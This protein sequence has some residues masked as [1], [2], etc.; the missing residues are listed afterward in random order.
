MQAPQQL[1]PG[2]LGPDLAQT[3]SRLFPDTAERVFAQ[4]GPYGQCH[5]FPVVLAEPLRGPAPFH[6][7]PIGQLIEQ[8]LFALVEGQLLQDPIV[9]IKSYPRRFRGQLQVENFLYP[10][11]LDAER[12]SARLTGDGHL[13]RHAEQGG[14]LVH[15]LGLLHFQGHRRPFAVPL[16]GDFVLR[17]ATTEYPL[18]EEP[19]HR[20]AGGIL[21]GLPEIVGLHRLPGVG[22]AVVLNRLPPQL[23]T[24][25]VT[26]HVQHQ[27]AFLVG[28]AVKH[29]RGIF[30]MVGDDGPAVVLPVFL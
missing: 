18:I 23:V 29:F 15:L 19:L 7:T 16:P 20:P 12:L 21:D 30:I 13:H 4:G 1:I 25:Q 22:P 10:V 6:V 5:G 11:N 17:V 2:R 28:M 27:R 8:L 9:G 26:D 14:Y 24:Q 3:F